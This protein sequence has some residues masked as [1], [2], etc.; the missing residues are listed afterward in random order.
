M[1]TE[2]ELKIPRRVSPT[3]FSACSTSVFMAL[4][5]ELGSYI[6]AKNTERTG[7]RWFDDYCKGLKYRPHLYDP[8]F[9]LKEPDT[10]GSCSRWCLPQEPDFH[11]TRR[12]L[13][14]Q[15]NRWAHFADVPAAELAELLA[16][17]RKLA[18]YL[19]LPLAEV[20]ARVQEHVRFLLDNPGAVLT[21][22][23]V[24]VLQAE[25]NEL[26]LRAEQV[27]SENA[28]LKR[29]L[30]AYE[31]HL[32]PRLSS[33]DPD[34]SGES[35]ATE[36]CLHFM[37]DGLGHSVKA[38]R[39][40]DEPGLAVIRFQLPMDIPLGEGD[41]VSYTGLD[42]SICATLTSIVRRQPAFRVGTFVDFGD[43]VRE[44]IAPLFAG[45][46]VANA[47]EIMTAPDGP[48]DRWNE[49][50]QGF[51]EVV[52][53]PQER[54]AIVEE[55]LAFGMAVAELESLEDANS[56]IE[57]AEL[58]DH[59]DAWLLSTPD[60]P[61]GPIGNI[62]RFGYRVSTERASAEAIRRGW[63]MD[64]AGSPDLNRVMA[65]L[66]WDPVTDQFFEFSNGSV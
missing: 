51:I 52:E 57:A 14:S 31:S 53:I 10:P 46:Q 12:E 2:V 25:V 13:K 56:V 35:G 49:F 42:G 32:L 43:G 24:R 61:I 15:R 22:D 3:D 60:A 29:Q 9:L 1:D 21:D 6:N 44:T 19:N 55:N 11:R 36:V 7:Q 8:E 47:E 63:L 66:D 45:L 16:N 64:E 23:E 17:V 37:F 30:G 48:L 58:Q 59:G 38:D 34:T 26:R 41:V 27:E 5:Q 20:V 50:W 28:E 40:V 39:L 54:V 62:A 4:G 65:E 18:R 33:F